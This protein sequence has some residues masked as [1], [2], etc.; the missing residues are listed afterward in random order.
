[1]RYRKL[2]VSPSNLQEL[3]RQYT[4]NVYVITRNAEAI[5]DP[6]IALTSDEGSA[7]PSDTHGAAENAT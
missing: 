5:V 3:E 4:E 7:A 6:H 1:M 2:E